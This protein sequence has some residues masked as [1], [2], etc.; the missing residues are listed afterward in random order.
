EDVGMRLLVLD[1]LSIDDRV[2]TA[3][4]QTDLPKIVFHLDS[5]GTTGQRHLEVPPARLGKE[6]EHAGQGLEP[7]RNQRK[8][9]GI[10]PVQIA[11]KVDGDAM[12]GGH[13]F[14]QV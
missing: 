5:G 1:V 11:G 8:I 13:P 7:A 3:E 4:R 10:K 9:Q 14:E 2:E 12:L 6:V